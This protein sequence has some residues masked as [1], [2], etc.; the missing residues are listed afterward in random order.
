MTRY[1]AASD[2]EKRVDCLEACK[3][4]RAVHEA[5]DFVGTFFIVGK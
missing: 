1:I 4:I 5:F 3:K 2:T